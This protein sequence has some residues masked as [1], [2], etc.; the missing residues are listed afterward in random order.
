MDFVSDNLLELGMMK[1]LAII[2]ACALV[3]VVFKTT[4]Y[5]Q[6][7]VDFLIFVIGNPV[8]DKLYL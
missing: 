1:E 4:F 5:L 8:S 3:L 7:V 2:T 6:Y